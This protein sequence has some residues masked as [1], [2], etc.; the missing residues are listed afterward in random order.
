MG[1]IGNVFLVGSAFYQ[2]WIYAAFFTEAPYITAAAPDAVRYQVYIESLIFLCI[3]LLAI[4][5][6][7]FF[8]K[9]LS[10]NGLAWTGAILMAGTV[11]AMALAGNE[12]WLGITAVHIAALTSGAGTALLGAMWAIC[13]RKASGFGIIAF[14]FVILTEALLILFVQLHPVISESALVAFPLVSAACGRE[15]LRRSGLPPERDALPV[16]S[17]VTP[18][19]NQMMGYS[20]PWLLFG[21]SLGLLIGTSG[22]GS[23]ARLNDITWLTIVALTAFTVIVATFVV[24]PAKSFGLGPLVKE[25]AP[26]PTT[27]KPHEQNRFVSLVCFCAIMALCLF[28]PLFFGNVAVGDG[29]IQIGAASS[30][31]GFSVM[32]LA[33][34]ML[35]ANAAE[36]FRLPVATVYGMGRAGRV[37]GVLLGGWLG[38]V[39]APNTSNLP[40]EQIQPIV[41]VI[42]CESILVLALY[43]AVRKSQLG[44]RIESR[45]EIEDACS[46]LSHQY[47][48]SPREGEVFLLL[49]RGRSQERIQEELHIAR[50]TA[51]THIHH[52]YQKLNVHSKQELIDLV[53]SHRE[54]S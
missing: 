27:D 53:E 45:T 16:S 6:L 20:A 23:F 29:D 2:T 30:I 33:T 34:L 8:G 26:I 37:L 9:K 24:S 5:V 36:V 12:S 42:S 21:I 13:F 54:K 47:G 28:V 46:Q 52:I 22:E 40:L 35:L 4:A 43:F 17:S 18:S 7:P 51:T 38:V 3:A 32:E 10:K 39:F 25:A 19:L 11:P 50:S 15:L 1:I 44:A 31:A 48:L 14:P 49:A 41:M